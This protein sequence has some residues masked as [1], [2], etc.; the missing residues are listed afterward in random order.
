MVETVGQMVA[1]VHQTAARWN[2][3]IA[4]AAAI[5]VAHRN[6]DMKAVESILRDLCAV[7]EEDLPYYVT[8]LDKCRMGASW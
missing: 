7:S 4:N 1:R 3:M 5:A 2:K 8:A 6:N